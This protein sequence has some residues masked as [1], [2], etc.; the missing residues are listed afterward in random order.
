M[1]HEKETKKHDAYVCKKQAKHGG[2]MRINPMWQFETD[3]ET[4]VP[5][6]PKLS[7]REVVG[8]NGGVELPNHGQVFE[9]V[10]ALEIRR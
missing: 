6:W 7:G 8:V 2:H 5:V 4:D 9:V 3:F 10:A 1:T